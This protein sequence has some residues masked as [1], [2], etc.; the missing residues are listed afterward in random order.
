[1]LTEEEAEEKFEDADED[2]DG[3]VSWS[4]HLADAYGGSDHDEII[5]NEDTNKVQ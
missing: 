4:E 3:L 2:S 5:Q 1:M